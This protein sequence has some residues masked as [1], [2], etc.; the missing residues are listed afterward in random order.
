MIFST[1]HTSFRGLPKARIYGRRVLGLRGSKALLTPNFRQKSVQML[2]VLFFLS[3]MKGS[4][5]RNMLFLRN[6]REPPARTSV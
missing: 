4:H 6:I 5:G 2:I 1:L 3:F